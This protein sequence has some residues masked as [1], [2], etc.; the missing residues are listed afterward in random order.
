MKSNRIYGQKHN[1]FRPYFGHQ[2]CANWK[3]CPYYDPFFEPIPIKTKTIQKFFSFRIYAKLY[4]VMHHRV[5]NTPTSQFIQFLGIFF[6]ILARFSLK[7]AKFCD[8]Y[9]I[10]ECIG[11]KMR[12]F[13]EEKLIEIHFILIKVMHHNIYGGIDHR[14][15]IFHPHRLNLS[16]I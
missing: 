5:Y 11:S 7:I 10:F 3:K 12:N 1:D 8:F 6:Q 2:T 14:C 13:D 16:P 4:K 15:V 9:Q